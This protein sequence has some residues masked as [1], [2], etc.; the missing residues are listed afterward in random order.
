MGRK[1]PDSGAGWV[2]QS[3]YV[4][5]VATEANQTCHP[6]RRAKDPFHL[7]LN[8][9]KRDKSEIQGFFALKCG[10]QNDSAFVGSFKPSVLIGE[11]L[12]PKQ[13]KP[14]ILSAGRRTLFI[15]F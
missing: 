10:A 14:V 6:E 3:I 7:L 8:Q 11:S 12:Q 4:N 15:G 5:G 2:I 9:T 13:I 1:T